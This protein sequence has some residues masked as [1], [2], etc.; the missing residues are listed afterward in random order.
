MAAPTKAE[1]TRVWGQAGKRE[2]GTQRTR[3]TKEELAEDAAYE[4]WRQAGGDPNVGMGQ[5]LA[6]QPQQS[7]MQQPPQQQQAPVMMAPPNPFG[8]QVPQQ[9]PQMPAGF[10]GSGLPPMPQMGVPAPSPPPQQALAVGVDGFAT[11]EQV[12][13]LNNKV[14]LLSQGVAQLLRIMYQKE[15]PPDLYQVLVEVCKVRP[16]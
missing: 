8:N 14:S 9:A 7:Q 5:A 1:A 6:A 11:E 2:D 13:E 15:G 12:T 4:A 16:Q 10:P 3:R